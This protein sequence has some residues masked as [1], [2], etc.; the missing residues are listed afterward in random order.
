MARLMC[1]VFFNLFFLSV[2]IFALNASPVSVNSI[3][4]YST[5]FEF[6]IGSIVALQIID[7]VFKFINSRGDKKAHDD[8]TIELNKTK[9]VVYDIKNKTEDLHEWHSKEDKDG[10]KIWYF[11]SS[12]EEAMVDLKG[13]VFS[14]SKSIDNQTI[15]MKT[16]VANVSSSNELIIRELDDIKDTLNRRS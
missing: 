13:A 16:I 15:F 5:L 12:L 2:A 8:M 14:L 4:T 7:R 10:V 6:G 3:G 1:Y 11:R 9:T